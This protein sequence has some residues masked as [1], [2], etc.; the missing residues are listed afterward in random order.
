M[1]STDTA[2]DVVTIVKGSSCVLF[3]TGDSYYFCYSILF[4]DITDFL[5]YSSFRV[6]AM[7]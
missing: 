1:Q 6:L 5:C 2:D 4:V 3:K 7:G